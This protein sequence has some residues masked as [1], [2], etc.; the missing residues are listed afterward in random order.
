M[1]QTTDIQLIT[2]PLEEMKASYCYSSMKQ[3]VY[4]EFFKYIIKDYDNNRIYII[5]L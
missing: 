3:Q 1:K 5:Y 4:W 2:I